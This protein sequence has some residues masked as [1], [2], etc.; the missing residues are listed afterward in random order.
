MVHKNYFLLQAYRIPRFCASAPR[1][2]TSLRDR[3]DQALGIE[4]QIS[5]GKFMGNSWENHRK[6]IGKWRF[7]LW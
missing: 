1:Q 6:T 4:G 5:P 3:Q 7:T 2:G